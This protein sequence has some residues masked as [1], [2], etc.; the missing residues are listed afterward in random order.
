[1]EKL[2]YLWRTHRLLLIAFTVAC[3]VTLVFAA[4]FSF[5]TLYWSDPAHR[6]QPL[7]GWMTV[8]YVAHSYRLP[9]EALADALSLQQMPGKRLTLAEIARTRGVTVSSLIAEIESV[10]MRLREEGSQP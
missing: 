3:L 1:M 2:A 8:G 10:I 9:R 6:N 5:Y 4:R 7:E